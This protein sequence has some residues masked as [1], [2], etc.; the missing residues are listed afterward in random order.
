MFIEGDAVDETLAASERQ[1]NE[2][3][4]RRLSQELEQTQVQLRAARE[5]SDA[6]NE[7]LQSIN[8]EYRWTSQELETSKGELQSINAELLTVNSALKLNLEA[9]SRAHGELQNLIVAAD[10]ATLFLDAGL[11]IKR[12]SE[13]VTELFSITQAD[14]R[15]LIT[16]F[17]HQL[18]YDGLINDAR[19]AL[20]ELASIR[21]QVRSRS[22]RWYDMRIR[23]YRAMD[24]K[25][26][27][28]VITFIDMP[29]RDT[30]EAALRSNE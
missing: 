22:G 13:R 11:R 17:T 10:F 6:A 1:V 7:E 28:V 16:D 9:I 8:E 20:T 21:R 2:E 5:E 29:A 24:D 23:P 15:R 27:G 30:R 3:P 4:L 19:K 25:I 26:D 12:F 18:E 14:E